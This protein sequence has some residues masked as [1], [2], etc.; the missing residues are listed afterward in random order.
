MALAIVSRNSPELKSQRHRDWLTTTGPG[1]RCRRET[2]RYIISDHPLTEEEWARERSFVFASVNS[3]LIQVRRDQ[4]VDRNASRQ[5]ALHQ[6]VDLDLGS[7][8]DLTRQSGSTRKM[9]LRSALR[10]Y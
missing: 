3:R 2:P 8:I 7:D 6:L 5:Q 4:D 1:T 10:I 9:L